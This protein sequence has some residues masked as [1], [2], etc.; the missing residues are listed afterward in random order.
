MYHARNVLCY[1]QNSKMVK[2]RDVILCSVVIF[3]CSLTYT[4]LNLLPVHKL[5]VGPAQLQLDDLI[6]MYLNHV[7]MGMHAVLVY[8]VN[9]Q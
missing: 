7:M 6:V 4:T 1:F 9:N 8:R 3:C 5:E 2:V